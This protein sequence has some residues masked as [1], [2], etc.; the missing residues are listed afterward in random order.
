MI[1]LKNISEFIQGNTRLII[2]KLPPIKAAEFMHLPEYKKEQV[3]YRMKVC[4]DS[5]K[6]KCQHCGCSTP[7]KFFVTK[8]CG[9]N[10]FP[11]LMGEEDWNK[12]KE[13][14]AI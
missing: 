14:N 11:D 12:Y 9:G 2:S 8:Q 1:T 5:C 6:F 7:G 10:K 4:E 3:A 13:E